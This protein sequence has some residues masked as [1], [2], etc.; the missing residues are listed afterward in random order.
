MGIGGGG[1]SGKL[2]TVV[3]ALGAMGGLICGRITIGG[4]GAAGLGATLLPGLVPRSG[5]PG[6][7]YASWD[8]IGRRRYL[9]DC[10]ICGGGAGIC[11]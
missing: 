8:G 2:G 4:A 6:G 7:L 9:F 1:L 10:G 3:F 11:L 5:T